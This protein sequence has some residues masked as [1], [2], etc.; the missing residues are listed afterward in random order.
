MGCIVYTNSIPALTLHNVS[1]D[2]IPTSDTFGNPPLHSI[3]L[4]TLIHQREQ[5]QAAMR[6][7]MAADVAGMMGELMDAGC[8]G[9]GKAWEADG[10]VGEALFRRKMDLY[11]PEET[12]INTSFGQQQVLLSEIMIANVGFQEACSTNAILKQRE[13]VIGT[14]NASVGAFEELYGNLQDGARFYTDLTLR[15]RQLGQTVA[16][17]CF[18]RDLEKKEMMNGFQNAAQSAAQVRSNG[19]NTRTH[20]RTHYALRTRSTL[21]AIAATTTRRHWPL[22]R[23]LLYEGRAGSCSVVQCTTKHRSLA[24]RFLAVTIW[25]S[26]CI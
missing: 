22:S 10:A 14:I 18:G 17:H 13:Q 12:L 26:R 5:A 19:S 3:Q 25:L 24:V 9:L 8:G 21:I 23:V 7:K 1:L 11:V 16:D 2:D 6:G 4:G 20:T 15:V